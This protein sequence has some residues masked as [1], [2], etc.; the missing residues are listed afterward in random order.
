[1]AGAP[2]PLGRVWWREGQGQQEAA[3]A[4]EEA[5]AGGVR[6]EQA[7]ASVGQEEQ[8]QP[9]QRRAGTEQQQHQAKG[10]S[11]TEQQEE[12]EQARASADA[13]RF[14]IV[15]ALGGP[16]RAAAA[17]TGWRGAARAVSRAGAAAQRVLEGPALGQL[18]R[19]NA[20]RRALVG[21]PPGLRRRR[22]GCD[23][24]ACPPNQRRST[25]THHQPNQPRPFPAPGV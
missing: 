25:N 8:Q 9:G 20:D 13:D 1:V 22:L 3:A 12:E 16:A 18:A 11:A 17:L 10:S 7:G 2:E 6:Q 23:L 15:S 24:A 21:R 14:G 4:Q 5:A 19:F